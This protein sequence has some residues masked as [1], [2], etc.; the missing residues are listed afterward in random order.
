MAYLRIKDPKQL[1]Q[2][3]LTGLTEESL[4]LIHRHKDLLLPLVDEIVDEL[5]DEIYRVDHLRNIIDNH[6]SLERLKAAQR[7]YLKQV[8]SPII[9]DAYT[10]NRFLIGKAHSK[11]GLDLPWFISTNRRYCQ[12]ISKL[13]GDL[14]PGDEA[15]HLLN[16]IE[17]TLNFDMQMTVDAYNEVE[18]DKAL[19][20]L[21]YE[22]RNL[23]KKSGLTDEDFDILDAYSGLLTFRLNEMM[24]RYK[25]VLT[26]RVPKDST[27]FMD[28][29]IPY[30]KNFLKQFFYEKMYRDEAAC[31]RIIRDWTRSINEHHVNDHLLTSL[32]DTMNE[33]F[34]DVFQE[35]MQRNEKGVSLFLA[36]FERYSRFILS[37]IKEFLK[38]YRFLHTYSF[39]N[40]YSYEISTFDFGKLTWIDEKASK[41]LENRG[42]TASDSIGKRCYEVF[43]DRVLPCI[44]CPAKVTNI[45]ESVLTTH[46]KEGESSYYKTWRFK[47]SRLAELDH[48]L[49][50]SQDITEDAKVIFDTVESLLDLAEFRDDDTGQ[51]VNRI[52]VLAAKLAELA[53]CDEKF[54]QDIGV[55]AKFHD[56]GKV[57]I[58]DSILNKPGKLSSEEWESMKKHVQIGHQILSKLE[59]PVIQ[60]AASIAK[61]HHERWDGT[62]Y[63]NQL[64]EKG[65]PLEGRIV[66]IVDVFDALLSKRAYKEPFAPEK[67]KEI[68]VEGK[69]SHFDPELTD[70]FLSMWDEFLE[71]QRE[72]TDLSQ[73]V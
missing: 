68:I 45:N 35:K 65:I 15:I 12:I 30:I 52:G 24:N 37:I 51:H 60:M 13:L 17:A 26:N 47:Q 69:G 28:S 14:L 11:I 44:G 32:V 23:E 7:H 9:D 21:R 41:L 19:Y 70:L 1:A 72:K 18:L 25:K 49:L 10:H 71:I 31:Y 73:F 50:V 48:L 3:S 34:R 46:E 57:G 63:P 39:L 59:L 38:P 22:F 33:V 6:S 5:Y 56:I 66:S 54:I 53:G 8:F 67:V 16:A 55:A 4:E 36:S 27:K 20:P 2:I 43:Y 29:F 58:P 42:A 40:M 62:G 61:T 64:K